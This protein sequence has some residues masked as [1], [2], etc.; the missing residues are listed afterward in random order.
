MSRGRKR[1]NRPRHSATE[2]FV[3][4]VGLAMILFVVALVLTSDA[5]RVELDPAIGIQ[6][7]SRP[8]PTPVPT[9]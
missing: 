8:Q 3:A 1:Q 4:A 5:C 7:A 2:Y 9:P 6:P